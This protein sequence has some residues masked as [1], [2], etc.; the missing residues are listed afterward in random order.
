MIL[1]LMCFILDFVLN[2]TIEI[3]FFLD[4]INF[5]YNYQQNQPSS[6]FKVIHN[7]ISLFGTPYAVAVFLVL[8][9]IPTKRKL[10]TLVHLTYYFY[11]TFIM[12]LIVQG[13]QGS[14][15][16]WYDLRIKNL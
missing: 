16:I 3:P 8:Y 2:V 1:C 10:T 15:P 14:R 13:L 11:A 9:Y 6:V 7:L 12:A 5:I 4:G